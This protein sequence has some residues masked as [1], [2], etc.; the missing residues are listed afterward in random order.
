VLVV[1]DEVV[2]LAADRGAPDPQ[3]LESGGVDQAS[4]GVARWVAEDAAGRA[5]ADGLV[6]APPTPDVVEAGADDLRFVGC[7]QERGADHD[8]GR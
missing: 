1:D 4:R 2:V 6:L 5:A 7:E 3:A 8:L